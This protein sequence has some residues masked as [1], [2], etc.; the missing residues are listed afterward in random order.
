MFEKI[1]NWVSGWLYSTNV[2]LMQEMI[3][4]MGS[5][6]GHEVTLLSH[7]FL[8]AE[9][10]RAEQL[11]QLQKESAQ[12]C[13][14]SQQIGPYRVDQRRGGTTR[15]GYGWLHRWFHRGCRSFLDSWGTA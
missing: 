7:R 10:A 11:D 2:F 15:V 6:R 5:L 13:R 8:P 1:F 14:F 4:T 9:V 12:R 3:D